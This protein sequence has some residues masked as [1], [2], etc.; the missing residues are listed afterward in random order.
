MQ[1]FPF[2]G[3]SVSNRRSALCRK[4]FPM[5]CVGLG[6]ILPA[7]SAFAVVNYNPPSCSTHPCT[8]TVT[9]TNGTGSISE[10]QGVIDDPSVQ[11]GDTVLLEAGTVWA[12][13]VVLKPKNGTGYLTI[14]STTAAGS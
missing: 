12:G 2:D 13:Q 1:Q 11:L 3:R 7:K 8:I 6:M 14:T 10:L 9:G 5:V 4:L